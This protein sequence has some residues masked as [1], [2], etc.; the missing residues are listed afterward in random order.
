MADEKTISLDNLKT[1]NDKI[2]ELYSTKT[3]L[4]NAESTIES[5]V[6]TN[7]QPQFFTKQE[8]QD[9]ITSKL[10]QKVNK[11]PNMGLSQN[12]FSDAYKDILDNLDLNDVVRDPLYCRTDNNFTNV[13]KQKLDNLTNDSK[14]IG[15]FD[16]LTDRDSYTETLTTGLWCS[17]L[18]DDDYNQ[19]KTKY[20]YDGTSWIYSGTYT[21]DEFLIDDTITDS[22]NVGWSSKKITDELN[23]KADKLTVETSI[24][25][26]NDKLD[27]KLE[28]NNIKAGQNIDIDV[29]SLGNLTINSTVSGGISTGGTTDYELLSNKPKINGITVIGDKT[30]KDLKLL[31]SSY[32]SA[33][34][35]GSVKLADKAK[36]IDI[37][38]QLDGIAKYYGVASGGTNEDNTLKLRPFPVGL[39][40]ERIETL[41][42]EILTKDVPQSI[43]FV[44][45]IPTVNCFVQAFKQEEAELNITDVFE[46]YNNEL[47]S[48]HTENIVYDDSGLHIKD[49][50][51]IDN[52]GLN[53]DGL[54]EIKIGDFIDIN[55]IK[56]EVID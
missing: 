54:Y 27:N 32:A 7:L 23:L 4:S 39:A 36:E 17:V 53:S 34:N 56:V 47:V 35:E 13:Y 6:I 46:D 42:F 30:A 41:D 12:N 51:N 48:N 49:I 21:D 45:E 33:I 29:D 3:D 37:E 11:M 40:T 22:E 24:D 2:K 20:I 10:D 26:I 50:Y 14:Y 28:V 25:E 31:D 16:S 55:N 38:G 8:C 44:R 15:L 5:N 1:Y 19:K 52:N 9:Y 18:L 43:P